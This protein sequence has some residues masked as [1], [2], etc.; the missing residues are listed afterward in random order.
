MAL[1]GSEEAFES[2]LDSLF[3][4]EAELGEEASPD[5]SG[6]IGQ[7]AQGNEP[8]HSTPF[9]YNYIGRQWK[10]A[11]LSRRIMRSFFDDTP[12]GLCGNEDAGQMSAWYVF[13]AMGLYP[14]NAVSGAFVIASPLFDRITV[15]VG[16]GRSF[17]V[18]AVGNSEE[19]IYVQSAELNGL[20][21]EKSYITYDD[22]VSGS[23][24]R[25]VMGPRPNEEF[26]T[27]ERSRPES[28]VY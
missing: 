3:T 11:E 23:V 9:L 6:L 27:A 14:A 20:A 16:E 13:A 25:L 17:T 8:N 26:G 22:I 19:D 4:V 24:L 1:F 21:Y 12:A 18:E 7:Y 28:R 5:I 10:S 15:D 2:K